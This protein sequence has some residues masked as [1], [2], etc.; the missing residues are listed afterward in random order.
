MPCSLQMYAEGDSEDAMIFN[1][2]Q[3]SH[4]NTLV[5]RGGGLGRP[6]SWAPARSGSSGSSAGCLAC[7]LL[8][9]LRLAAPT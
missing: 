7:Q 2:T 1:C 8:P 4:Q 9:T 5:S 3:R 6:G